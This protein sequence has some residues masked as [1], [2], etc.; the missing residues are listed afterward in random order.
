LDACAFC[1]A[2][3]AAAQAD[4]TEA[5]LRCHACSLQAQVTEHANAVVENEMRVADE[6]L[7][8]RADVVGWGHGVV[9]IG[10]SFLFAVGWN[11]GEHRAWLWPLLATSVV[12]SF[13]LRL[14]AWWSLW[15]AL[16]LDAIPAVAALLF[17]LRSDGDDRLAG[18]LM[19][20]VPLGLLGLLIA[21]RRAF[22]PPPWLIA[23]SSDHPPA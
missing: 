1:G 11:H 18:L 9:W 17:V 20:A 14:R 21:L 3:V 22:P 13:A 2:P 10:C 5:G 7:S 12:L 15:I 16:L 6:R 23:K 4:L 19:A 8:A